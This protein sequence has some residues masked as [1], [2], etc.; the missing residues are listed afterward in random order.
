LN[1]SADEAI[2]AA[3]IPFGGQRTVSPWQRKQRMSGLILN[4]R[5]TGE[6]L[7]REGPNYPRRVYAKDL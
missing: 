6:T 2:P 5:R 7:D 1:M 3:V 4:H